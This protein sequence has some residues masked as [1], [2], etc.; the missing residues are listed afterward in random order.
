MAGASFVTET[1]AKIILGSRIE[2]WSKLVAIDPVRL[3]LDWFKSTILPHEGA[4][5]SRMRHVL[6]NREDVEDIVAEVL[7]RAY[8][9]AQF[10]AVTSGR[11]YLFQIARNLL[12]DE[13]RR[14]KIVRLE[15]IADLNLVEDSHCAERMLIARDQLR[16][17]EAVVDTLPPQARRAFIL[18]RIH[19]RPVKEIAEEMGLSV[20]TVDKHIAKATIRVMQAMAQ[21]EDPGCDTAG[22]GQSAKGRD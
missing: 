17:L 6:R 5:R 20:F 2:R 22:H 15:E 16:R 4:L 13:A 14:A 8:G 19:D 10:Q 11:A 7:T 18:R 3:R 21:F 9:T 12:I 1:Q